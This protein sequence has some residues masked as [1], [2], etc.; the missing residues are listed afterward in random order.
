MKTGIRRRLAVVVAA[1]VALGGLG[2]LA[3]AAP[4]VFSTTPV[5]GWSTN[6]TV[7]AVRIVGDT[8][9]AG[10]DFTTVRP[11]GSGPAIARSRLAA[12]DVKTG[13]LRS[14]FSADANGRVE[15]LA[16]DGT[17]LFVGGDFTTIKGV[18]KSR[19]AAVDLTSGNVVS[20]WTAN[21]SSHV[22]ALRVHSPRLYV[23]GAFGTLAGTTRAKVGAVSTASGAIDAAFNPVLDDAVHGI[24]TSPDGATVYL[25]GDFTTVGGQPRGYLAAVPATT[26]GP[27]PVALQYP[28]I[29]DPPHGLQ[30]I[31][32]SPA[33]DRVFGV[34]SQNRIEAWS[35]TTG[36]ELYSY[37][38]DGDTQAVRYSNGNVYFGFHEGA[39]GDHTVRLLVADAT[40]GQLENSYRPPIDSFFGIRALD[41]SPDALVLGGEFLNVNGVATQGIAIM[42]PQSADPTP[43]TAPGTPTVT[44]TT[45]TTV[46]LAWTPGTDNNAVAGYRVLRNGVE[47]GYPT[48]TT[49]T[50][51]GLAPDTDVTYAVQTIDAAGNLSTPSGTVAA[52][53]VLL[54]VAAGAV[55]KYLD[56]GSNQG[57]AWRSPG[58]DDSTW[59]SGRAELGYGDG[60]EATIVGSGPDPNNRYLTT[61]FRRTF[62]VSDPG[63]IA[64]LAVNLVRDDGAAVYLNGTEVARSD[65]PAGTITSATRAVTAV[66]GA[67]EAQWFTFPVDPAL[68]VAG[69][70]T[71]AVELHQNNATSSDISFNLSLE[72]TRS[73]SGPPPTALALSSVTDTAASLQWNAPSGSGTTTGYRVYR[74][75]TLVGSPTD[76]TFTD[77]GLASGQSYSYTVS[78]VTDGVETAKAGPVVATTTT[79]PPPTALQTTGITD[80]TV[81][82]AWTAPAGADT[83]TGYRVYRGATLI[84][85]P[86][87]TTYTDTGLNTGQAVVYSVSAIT[88]GVETVRS[89][90]LSVTTTDSAAPTAPT[91]LNATS[92]ASDRVVLTWTASTDN[93][94]VTG[95]DVLRNGSVIGT[96]TGTTLTDTTVA[97]NQSYAYTVRA[98]DAAGNV[99]APSTALNVTTPAFAGTSFEDT[100]DSGSFTSGRWTTTK[101]TTV[102]GTTPG[103]FWARLTATA[104]PANLAW[105]VN[106]LEQGHRAWTLRGYFRIDSHNANQSVSLVELKTVAG[107]S[108]YVYTN[109]TTGRCTL[110][111][112]GS[113]AITAF[114][115]DD[116]AWHL[117]ELKGDFGATTMTVDWRIDGAALPSVTATGQTASTARNM[118][119]GE[120]GGTPTNVQNW[121][122]VKLTLADTALPFLG[123]FAPFG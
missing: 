36:A 104:G 85:S 6:G 73:Q 93:V 78:A 74:D 46:A 4:I 102:A 90:T 65:L 92:V 89:S 113:T 101:A 105:P 35:T 50:D 109:A 23:G 80:T 98:K 81:D 7:W 79:N 106:V 5:A 21:A 42:P 117:L 37:R 3:G 83:T 99:S 119:L 59:A 68:L 26:G 71:L 15:S 32:I 63:S 56:N 76:T 20:G 43:P 30:G 2:V 44:G 18:S 95:Y 13:A 58:F 77:P 107:R 110:S 49:F 70:N 91:G 122:N 17:K 111:I 25:A 29:G 27:A 39:I 1:T 86:T 12:W 28:V 108:V 10:G 118:Y 34:G 54:P 53:T 87:G 84:G 64:A 121:D 66:G 94:A 57:T 61:Y 33:G 9:Y 48:T 112:A 62:T 115:C 19:L 51:T 88:N 22:Y 114:R 60:D 100:F 116:G 14:G 75:G 40:T 123:G 38:V 47:V 41:A 8:V 52:H 11:P 72:A 55:W 24:T 97:A 120:P 103:S 31:D 67:E 45:A 96:P 82:L 16:S 69:T